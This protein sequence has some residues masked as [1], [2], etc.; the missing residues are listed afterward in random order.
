MRMKCENLK[1]SLLEKMQRVVE[2]G[3]EKGSSNWLPVI[4]LKE[5]NFDLNKREF[6]NAIRLRYDR[7]IP[8]AQSVCVCGV[9]F[10]VDH[11]MIF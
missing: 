2:L 3:G 10:T 7:P 8:D 6:R 9:R 5:M 11:T 4:P 1:R